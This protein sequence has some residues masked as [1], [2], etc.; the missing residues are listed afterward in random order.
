MKGILLVT[1]KN[2]ILHYCLLA[3]LFSIKR[4]IAIGEIT[5]AFCSLIFKTIWMHFRFFGHMCIYIMST[6]GQSARSFLRHVQKFSFNFWF[7][8]QSHLRFLYFIL[9]HI[10][11]SAK[12]LLR[13]FVYVIV[14]KYRTTKS[15][16]TRG[17]GCVWS[18]VV[19]LLLK[20][21]VGLMVITDKVLAYGR[22]LGTRLIVRSNTKTE[23]DIQ[24]IPISQLPTINY[25][26]YAIPFNRTTRVHRFTTW[27]SSQRVTVPRISII[28]YPLFSVPINV[29]RFVYHR[30]FENGIQ[31]S[32][33]FQSGIWRVPN[34]SMCFSRRLL[35]S[36]CAIV[37]LFSFG[38]YQLYLFI[39]AL[40]NPRNI[41]KVNYSLT[42]HLYDRNGE[43]L[44][45]FYKDANR[46][47]IKLKDLPP[48]VYQ[49]TIAIEDKDFYSHIGVSPIYGVARAIKDWYATGQVQGGSTIT[50][51]LVKMS[52]LSSERTFS[53]KIKEAVLAIQAEKM[54]R[55]DQILQM[56]M[57]QVPYGGSAY[58]VEEASRTF[59]DKSA[60]DLTIAEAAL[61]AG[62]PQSP[63]KRSPFTDPASAIARRDQ[64]LLSMKEMDFISENEYVA[65]VN[66]THAFRQPVTQIQAPHFVFYTKDI[67]QS[68]FSD[69]EI[70]TVGYSVYTTLDLSIQKMAQKI[71]QEELDKVKYLHVTNGGVIVTKPST[72]EILAMVGS[73]KY[74]DPEGTGAYNVTTALRQPGST[75]KPL[76]YALALQ[77]G[78][79]AATLIDDAPSTFVLS[80]NDIYR[81]VN[82]DG[83]FRGRVTVRQ[84]LANSYNIPAVK[85]IERIGV[86]TFID[87]LRT[88]G[89][90]SLEDYSRYG[91]S[92]SLGGGEVSM[93]DMSVAYGTLANK[94][95]RM[96]LTPIT[97]ISDASGR[98]IQFP[99][100]ESEKVMGENQTYIV[101]DILSDNQAR[102]TAFGYGSFLEI[103]GYKVAVKT[104]TTNDK[105]DNWTIGYTPD[106]LVTVWVGNNDGTPMNPYLTSGVT[107]AAPIWNRV[108]KYLLTEKGQM[109]KHWYEK[110]SN[111]I[112]KTCL[113]RSELFVSGTENSVPCVIITPKPLVKKEDGPNNP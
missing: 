107:G 67:L 72:G 34:F 38:W 23:V 86:T 56:Y 7:V 42:T 78:Y 50:Q 60:K 48:Y 102:A 31:Q 61:L 79:T 75:L 111:I 28:F 20:T 108:M 19:H 105:K 63:T 81:P 12:K 26:P 33:P 55:K 43:T 62:L 95:E 15:I 103:P 93:I 88:V 37:L 109:A 80:R 44:Y 110:P 106:Y 13:W 98:H 87:F 25:T 104:G 91:L 21:P 47:P 24:P 59:F 10:L 101:S 97:S 27:L 85:T 51:Q 57:N 76:L 54:F 2:R 36:V 53:R 64:V 30:I 65:S 83:R 46:T 40:P 5:A 100:H 45:E 70:D 22:L 113:G 8:V 3:L 94:G 29:R 6:V 39:Q 84:S 4:F 11:Q 49:A 96:N 69:T 112:S 74:F 14:R 58:G 66:T 71:L 77:K 52:L 9:Q 41:G 16:C 89:I 17:V 35:V 68:Y 1:T 92:L 90:S 32:L 82:Y 18:V 99:T 73:A